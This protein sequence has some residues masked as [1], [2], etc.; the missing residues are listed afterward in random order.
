MVTITKVGGNVKVDTGVEK[1]QYYPV[2]IDNRKLLLD[3]SNLVVDIVIGKFERE[4]LPLS[5]LSIAGVIPTNESEF[6]TQLALVFPS[7]ASSGST[8]IP[9]TAYASNSEAVAALGVGK[10]Y[11]STTKIGP[12]NDSSPLILLTI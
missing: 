10:L 4:D 9:A 11:K 12:Q 2:N 5:Q 3:V 6:D 8:T 1:P 7:P